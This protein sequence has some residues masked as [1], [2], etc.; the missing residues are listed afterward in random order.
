VNG[1]RP[2]AVRSAHLTCSCSP[3]CAWR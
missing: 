3:V 1:W 2:R